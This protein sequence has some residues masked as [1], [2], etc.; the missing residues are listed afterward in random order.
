MARGTELMWDYTAKTVHTYIYI[1]MYLRHRASHSVG[2]S[3]LYIACYLMLLRDRTPSTSEYHSDFATPHTCWRCHGR[4]CSFYLN[5]IRTSARAGFQLGAPPPPADP[6]KPCTSRQNDDI[7]Q[8]CS[9]FLPDF[10]LH[11]D[12]SGVL[13]REWWRW[14]TIPTHRATKRR[15]RYMYTARP[16]R[17]FK[18]TQLSTQWRRTF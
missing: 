2:V 1:Y 12:H 3:G 15:P 11:S 16:L 13:A 9:R 17:P 14:R 4:K 8:Y 7:A 6:S 10:V 18:T 5:R